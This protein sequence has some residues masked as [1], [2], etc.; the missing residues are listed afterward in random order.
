MTHGL[1]G[2]RPVTDDFVVAP[3]LTADDMVSAAAQGV[4][5]VINNRPDD[6]AP[7]QP[8][9]SALAA[10]AAEAGIGY[11]HLPVRGAPTKS[12]V[13]EMRAAV[14]GADGVALA[15]CAS[16]A[17]SIFTWALGRQASGTM[18]RDEILALTRQAGYDL[19]AHLPR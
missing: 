14:D 8:P 1:P 17:R 19:S 15:F 11:L 13:A 18:S 4:R 3:Q 10:A 6:E 2:V 7:G 5:L 16:G 12:Q 9:S